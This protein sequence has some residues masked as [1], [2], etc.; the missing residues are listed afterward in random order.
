ML[1]TNQLPATGMSWRYVWGEVLELIDE[2][3]CFNIRGI[4]DELCDVYTTAM[5]AIET[6][7]GIP[8]PIFWERSGRSWLGRVEVWKQ[9]FK[10]EGLVFK[11]KYI[12]FGGNYKKPWKVAKA[13]ELAR[14]DQSIN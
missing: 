4:S 9:I 11:T 14:K 7:S 12:R 10:A 1:F 3:K 2:F 13:F 6:S 8:M 5:C